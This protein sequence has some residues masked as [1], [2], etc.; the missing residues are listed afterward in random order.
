MTQSFPTSFEGV[1]EGWHRRLRKAVDAHY[2]CARSYSTRHHQLGMCSTILTF[3]ATGFIFATLLGQPPSWLTITI[4]MLSMAAAIIAGVHTWLRYAERSER[5]RV[6]AARYASICREI[7][8]LR[9]A[10]HK[11]PEILARVDSVRRT[12]DGISEDAPP[13]DKSFWQSVQRA[14]G[15]T[16]TAGGEVIRAG[17]LESTKGA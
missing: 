6:V 1:L 7:E 2:D 12:I 9:L 8:Q 4:G 16:G 11:L 13:I 3:A 10:D 5:H 15:G 17:E 14:Y